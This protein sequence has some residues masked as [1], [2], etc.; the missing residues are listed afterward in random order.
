MDQY[1]LI[2]FLGGWTS[3][4]QLFWCSPGVQGFD[5]LPF[6]SFFFSDVDSL[7][8][9]CCPCWSNLLSHLH[10]CLFR[11]SIVLLDHFTSSKYCLQLIYK[12]HSEWS[13][14]IYC[15]FSKNLLNR[16]PPINFCW[17]TALAAGFLRLVWAFRWSCYMRALAT[18]WHV[19]RTGDF[20]AGGYQPRASVNWATSKTP[21]FIFTKR[22]AIR[23]LRK[24]NLGACKPA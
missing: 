3:I 24:Q 22:V 11:P 2:P 5:T 15:N 16:Y 18:P 9:S 8:I 23:T 4:Y 7:V 10:S 13:N 19:T 14:V 6:V 20:C 21:L 17:F 12:M 1:L